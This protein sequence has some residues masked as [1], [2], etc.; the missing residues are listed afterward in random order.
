[1]A[2]GRHHVRRQGRGDGPTLGLLLSRLVSSRGQIRSR[3]LHGTSTWMPESRRRET[4]EIARVAELVE[5]LLECRR[6]KA[7]MIWSLTV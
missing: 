2:Q 1:M 5:I 4:G 7:V 3:L 6:M